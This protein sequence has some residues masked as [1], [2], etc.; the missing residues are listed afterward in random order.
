FGSGQDQTYWEVYGDWNE[1]PGKLETEVFYLLEWLCTKSQLML[2]SAALP[3]DVRRG[4]ATPL[5]IRICFG[6][7][8]PRA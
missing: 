2:W 3:P 1:D 5:A 6:A 8:P 7:A 4:S